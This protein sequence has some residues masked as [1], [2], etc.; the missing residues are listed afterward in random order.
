MP[1]LTIHTNQTLLPTIK[2]KL[3]DSLVAITSMYLGKL[4][5][6][7]NIVI[8]ENCGSWYCNGQSTSEFQFSLNIIITE[9][10]NNPQEKAQ[11]L[12]HSWQL[13]EEVFINLHNNPNYI[14]I[15]EIPA[16]DWGYNGQSQAARLQ[17]QGEHNGV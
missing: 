1:T 16:T 6:L 11:W 3:A 15:Q 4:P 12:K 9:G 14:S 8:H 13:F 2:S 5:T 7:T 10:T 17:K